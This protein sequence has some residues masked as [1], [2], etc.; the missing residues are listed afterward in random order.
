MKLSLL[1][2]DADLTLV[3]CSGEINYEELPAGNEP[4]ALLLG[5]GG[6]ARKVVLG[7]EKVPHIDSVGV[8]WL[9]RCHKHF[10]D[11][12]G[13]LVLCAPRDAVRQVFDLLN[14]ASLLHIADHEAA[15]RILAQAAKPKP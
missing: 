3:Q 12:G 4:L 8:G 13:R 5:P 14:L 15:A 7:L 2:A 9:V 1:S 11:A 10:Q 6:Y